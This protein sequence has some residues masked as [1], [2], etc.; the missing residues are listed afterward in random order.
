MLRIKWDR[1]V[2]GNRTGYISVLEELLEE[3]LC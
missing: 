2:F 1:L 3:E